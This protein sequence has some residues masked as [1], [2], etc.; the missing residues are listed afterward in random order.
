M[1]RNKI[2]VAIDFEE[3]SLKALQQSYHLAKLFDAELLLLY[4]VEESSVLKSFFTHENYYDNILHTA[5]EKLDELEALARETALH[6]GVEVNSLIVKGKPYEQIIQTAVNEHVILIV[7]GKNSSYEKPGRKF[8]GSNTFNVVRAAPCPVISIKGDN[9]YG[10]FSNILLPLDFTKPVQKQ[11]QQSVKL[12]GYFG[13]TIHIISVLHGDN[14]MHKLLKQVQ[15]SQAKNEINKNGLRCTA[16]VV[17]NKGEPV[18]RTIIKHARKI[19]ANLIIVLTQQKKKVVPF[20][21]G[22]TAQEIIYESEMPVLSII[23]SVVFS[24]GVVTSFVDPMGLMER[25]PKQI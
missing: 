2:L 12:A 24:P 3:Q 7:M 20:F 17:E 6:M 18:C 13:S 25:H 15:L 4:V 19:E 1:R 9:N 22:S 11:I 10:E 23:P 5:K 14:K 16:E 21:I 8:I